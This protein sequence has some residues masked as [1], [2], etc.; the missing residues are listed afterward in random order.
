MGNIKQISIK[1]RTHNVFNDMITIEDFVSNVL[2]IDKK[3]QKSI[4]IYYI[5]YIAIKDFG[6]VRINSVNPLYI[7]TGKADRYFE[8]KKGNKYLIFASTDKNKVVLTKHIELLDKIGFLI[9]TINGSEA[10]EYEK[11]CMKIKFSSNDK[12]A[13]NK[14]LNL[15]NLTIAVRSVFQ[16]DNKYYKQVFLDEC[17]YEL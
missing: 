8:Q 3:S 12:L 16:E 11:E 14:V 17:L 9:Q 5:G 13:F 4:D 1:N 2:K 6:H 10:G 15:D 7:I